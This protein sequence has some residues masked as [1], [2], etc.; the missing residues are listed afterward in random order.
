V[1]DLRPT[2]R[3]SPFIDPDLPGQESRTRPSEHSLNTSALT[4]TT[5]TVATRKTT[6]PSAS[7][8][9]RVLRRGVRV[10]VCATVAFTLIVA[11]LIVGYRT[12]NPPAST[13]ML[14]QRVT[15]VEITHTWVPMGRISPQ[16]A[17]AV[18]MSE[19]SR[20]CRHT[21][22]DWQ[23]LEDAFDRARDG[24]PRGGS[25]LSMQLTKN[26]FLWPSKS[27]LR[28]AIELPLTLAIE[29]AWSKRRILEIYLNV[30]EWGPGVFGAE[31]AAQY[32]FSKSAAALTEA[33]AALLAVSLPNPI[34]RDAG[35]PDAR[36]QRLASV[37]QTRMRSSE[38][39]T[40]C[41]TLTRTGRGG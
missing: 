18:V 10:T 3:T 40:K 41:L 25:T 16:L 19:D 1:S 36:L 35:E 38:S 20:F 33:E 6:Q 39:Y 17:R 7:R 37:I 30:A 34:A 21:G 28:K 15:G 8:L 9:S 32:H 29:L 11:T 13:L 26:L 4:T 5:V 22:I 24:V 14:W 23:E 12:V 31:A 2:G 27:Y